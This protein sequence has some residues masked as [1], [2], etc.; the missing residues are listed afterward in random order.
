MHHL[1]KRLPLPCPLLPQHWCALTSFTPHHPLTVHNYAAAVTLS[2]NVASE[3]SPHAVSFDVASFAAADDQAFDSA[4]GRS[5]A[6]PLG[7]SFCHPQYRSD[8]HPHSGAHSH[9][10][11]EANRV[12]FDAAIHTAY[13]ETN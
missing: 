4:H 2:L 3:R 6:I 13:G 1:L 11:I 8:R 12:S 5:H 10:V 9:A 7:C